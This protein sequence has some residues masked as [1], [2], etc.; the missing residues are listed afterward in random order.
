MRLLGLPGTFVCLGFVYAFF[1]CF[2]A[3]ILRSPPPGYIPSP[4]SDNEDSNDKNDVKMQTAVESQSVEDVPEK[5]N[6]TLL[7]SLKSKDFHLMYIAFLANIMFGL[8]LIARLS[9]M[10]RDIFAR[11]VDE[12][13]TVVAINSGFNLTGRLFFSVLSDFLGRKNCYVLMLTAQV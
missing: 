8:V 2:A 9:N 5:D 3:L 1:M 7:E 13:A 11:S 12:A 10:I 6:P 4:S